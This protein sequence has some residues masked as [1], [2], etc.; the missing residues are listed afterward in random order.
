MKRQ[1]P[2]A[3]T[4]AGPGAVKRH[5]NSGGKPAASSG[6]TDLPIYRHRSALIEAIRANNVVV[7]VGDTG[8]GKTTQLPQY[9]VDAGLAGPRGGGGSQSGNKQGRR[10]RG[11]V[12]ITQPRRVAAI[13]V[14]RRVASERGGRGRRRGGLHRA[15]RRQDQPA[16]Q[17]QVHDGWHADPRVAR[18]FAPVGLLVHHP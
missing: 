6:A 4:P 11:M 10:K 3:G 7:V 9:L 8:S 5:N 14:A 16:N 2:P 13:T 17:P 15:V 1:R 12:A 18:R